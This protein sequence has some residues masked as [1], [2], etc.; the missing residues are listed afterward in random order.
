MTIAA[1]LIG[2]LALALCIDPLPPLPTEKG[3][4]TRYSIGVMK[5]VTKKRG[6]VWTGCGAAID[7]Q[8]VGSF[9]LVHG[10]K[11]GVE[12]VCQVVDWSMPKDKARHVKVNLMEI[13]SANHAAVC[14]KADALS[15]W[16]Q[17][18]VLIRRGVPDPRSPL[19]S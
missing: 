16:R 19:G 3:Y 10:V 8:K 11:T 5:R 1:V 13:D 18:P 4:L 9:V 17:C 12:R 6:M 14:G 7:N 15:G 2:V